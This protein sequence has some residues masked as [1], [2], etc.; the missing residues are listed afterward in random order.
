M[1]QDIR[2][3]VSDIMDLPMGYAAGCDMLYT[4][5]PWEQGLV[6]MFE[7]LAYRDGNVERAGNQIDD[8]LDRLFDLTPA[9]IPAFIEYSTKGHE[10]VIA[11]GEKHGFQCTHVHHCMQTTKKPYVIVQ[12]NSDMPPIDGAGGWEP[13]Q[14]ALDHHNPTRVFEPFAGHGQHSRRMWKHGCSV[15]AA[16]LNPHRAAKLKEWFDL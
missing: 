1:A 7:T 6:K 14:A 11:A 16:E 13:L 3:V 8:I 12:F 4:D 5:P 10:R 2:F 15:T 9:G